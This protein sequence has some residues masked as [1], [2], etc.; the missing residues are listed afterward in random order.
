MSISTAE[1]ALIEIQRSEKVTCECPA[2]A[3]LV[4]WVQA[5]LTD[6]STGITIRIV[7]SNEMQASNHQ[8]R[9]RD[10]ATNVLSFPAEFPP[11]AGVSYL[12][13][14]LICA[15]VLKQESVDQGKSLYDHW[16][17]IVIHGVLHLQGFDHENNQDAN[18]MERREVEI[19]S[20]LGIADPYRVDS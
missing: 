17:H 6:N 8:W 19:L 13:D 2:D 4:Q 15:E 7:D 18:R 9:G 14:I 1:A 3:H 16:A 11:E 12:G 5:V 10:K 20:T